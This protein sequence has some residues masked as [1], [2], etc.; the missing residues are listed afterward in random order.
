[1]YF[2]A[3]VMAK[4][5]TIKYVLLTSLVPDFIEIVAEFLETP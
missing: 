5:T 2:M 1:M 4:L 3:K